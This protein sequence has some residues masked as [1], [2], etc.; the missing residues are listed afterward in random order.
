MA[1][2]LNFL[3]QEYNL[4]K[5]IENQKTTWE[6]VALTYAMVIGNPADRSK[7]NWEAVNWA[8]RHRWDRMTMQKIKN[9]AWQLAGGK[10]DQR[11]TNKW[12]KIHKEKKDGSESK[13]T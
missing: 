6:Q 8:I 2:V 7:V 13:E 9:K 4:L 12:N 11:V 10:L 3:N 5:Q 1:L